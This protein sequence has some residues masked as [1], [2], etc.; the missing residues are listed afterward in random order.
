MNHLNQSEPLNLAKQDLIYTRC[1]C[2]ENIYMLCKLISEKDEPSLEF[3]NVVFISNPNKT[4]PVWSQTACVDAYPVVWDYHVILY[5]YD[6]VRSVVYDFDSI[7]PFPCA[8]EEYVKKSFYPNLV[9]PDMFKRYFRLIPAVD[10]LR[11][12]ASDRSHMLKDGLYHAPPPTY[13]A[14]KTPK[15]TMNLPEYIDMEYTVDPIY[16]VVV[17][18]NTF[19]KAL[20]YRT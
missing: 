5:Y 2:E 9:I 17:D 12:F 20:Q 11:G 13:P 6:N 4:I 16:G 19:F 15:N 14:I 7:L 1:Y 3:C 8:S 10:Y 18:E